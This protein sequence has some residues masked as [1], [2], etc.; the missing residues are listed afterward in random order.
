MKIQKSTVCV[1]N[2][3]SPSALKLFF[4]DIGHL[5]FFLT[6][7]FQTHHA[8]ITFL[9]KLTQSLASC[10]TCMPSSAIVSKW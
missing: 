3:N 8:C 1:K 10:M 6:S 5:I 9:S 7:Q 2:S 4:R